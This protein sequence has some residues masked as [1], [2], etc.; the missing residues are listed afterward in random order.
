MSETGSAPRVETPGKFRLDTCLSLYQILSCEHSN[1]SV[2]MDVGLLPEGR[3][4]V[5]ERELQ[6]RKGL[7]YWTNGAVFPVT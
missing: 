7:G 6:E 4:A 5:A 3:V 1:Q 2:G